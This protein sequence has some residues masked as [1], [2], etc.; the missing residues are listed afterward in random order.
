MLQKHF[1]R[2]PKFAKCVYGDQDKKVA[3]N[4]VNTPSQ[5]YSLAK[6]GK[7]VQSLLLPAEQFNDGT[8]FIKG[9]DI[10]MD[11]QR[12]VDVNDMWNAQKDIK[13]K[14]HTQYSSKRAS[15]KQDIQNV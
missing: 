7:P 6:Q 8:P 13:S 3:P 11:R 12:S 2:T 5:M 4:L 1:N 9:F 15:K 14:I 10:P